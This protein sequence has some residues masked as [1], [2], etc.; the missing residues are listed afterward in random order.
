MLRAVHRRHRDYDGAMPDSPAS[1]SEWPGHRLG[2]PAAGARSVARIGRR[3]AALAIDWALA[4]IVSLAFFSNDGFATLTIFAAMQ[5]VMLV[6]AGGS[7][8]HLLLR[9]RVVPV[10]G[11]YLGFWRPVVR[12]L[13]ICLVIPAVIWDADQRGMHDR[14]AGTVLV[15]V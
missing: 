4:T 13:L 5:I 3:I 1:T 10:H 15:R 8:G 6:T 14:A 7:I 11:G 9:M 2:L 12:T